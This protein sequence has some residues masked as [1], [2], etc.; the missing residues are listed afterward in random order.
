MPHIVVPMTAPE[1][2]LN[3]ISLKS[4][5]KRHVVGG[6]ITAD[7]YYILQGAEYTKP[8]RIKLNGR[9]VCATR[10][11]QFQV[12]DI[13]FWKDGK[14]IPRHLPLEHLITADSAKM[15]ISNQNN[16]R[17]GETLYN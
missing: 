11:S 7:F 12:R 14:I 1:A 10:T 8:H 2:D 4:D 13:K 3:L 15:N 17:L 5:K 16:E 9:L 6:I